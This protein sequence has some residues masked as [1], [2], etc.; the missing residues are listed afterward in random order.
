MFNN[1]TD[2]SLCTLFLRKSNRRL[3]LLFG[4]KNLY[5]WRTAGPCVGRLKYLPHEILQRLLGV[6]P[7]P[8]VASPPPAASLPPYSLPSP[9]LQP[10]LGMVPAIHLQLGSRAQPTVQ[11]LQKEWEKN[12][13]SKL[14]R[15][16]Q[17]LWKSFADLLCFYTVFNQSIAINKFR[18]S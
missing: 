9:P 13:L 1:G 10:P 12:R 14:F 16:Q 2:F 18:V 15:K 17:N 6:D 11:T 3:F 8:P 7:P 4:G 5:L